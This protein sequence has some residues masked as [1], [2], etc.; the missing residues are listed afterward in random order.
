MT[1]LVTEIVG[2]PP[3]CHDTAA[4]ALRLDTCA[5]RLWFSSTTSSVQVLSIV[6]A[7]QCCSERT[8]GYP[9]RFGHKAQI[10][11]GVVFPEPLGTP[12]YCNASPHIKPGHHVELL[13]REHTQ[14]SCLFL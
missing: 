13:R 1:D 8:S 10:G 3:S 9:L 7:F 5:I 4:L 6:H 14:G 2:G 12:T 11:S